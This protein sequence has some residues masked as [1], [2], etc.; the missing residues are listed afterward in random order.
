ME[1]VMETTL[2]MPTD[3]APRTPRAARAELEEMMQRWLDAHRRAEATFDWKNTLGA[4]YTEDAEYRWDLG[5]DQTFVAHGLQEIR[6]VAIGEQMEGFDGWSYP[7]ERVVIDEQKGEIVGFWRQVSP[8]KRS[9]GSFYAVPGLG[10]SWF[11]YAGNFKWSHQQDFFD[12]GS[13][14]ATLRDLAGAG[15]LPDKLKRKMQMLSR[16]QRM[17]GYAP[18]PERASPLR[19]LQGNLALG[20]IALLGR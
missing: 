6:E 2:Q 14:V 9:D 1:D 11:R 3:V 13:V 7:Y 8:F 5:P 16:G 18:R 19:K 15:L 17:A 4:H 20:R 10:S 12:L